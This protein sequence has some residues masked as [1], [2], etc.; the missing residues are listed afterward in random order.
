MAGEE[1]AGV[2]CS[3]SAVAVP[4]TVPLPFVSVTL[5]HKPT[6][7][8]EELNIPCLNLYIQLT[9]AISDKLWDQERKKKKSKTYAN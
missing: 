9:L 2:G 4:A 6:Y 7:D 3:C 5:R 1:E 8:Q